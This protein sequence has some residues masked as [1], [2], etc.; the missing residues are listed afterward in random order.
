MFKIKAGR[1]EKSSRGQG[2]KKLKKKKEE[3]R[4]RMEEKNYIMGKI[5][6]D[7]EE[8][9]TNVEYKCWKIRSSRR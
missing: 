6:T 2:R 7:E 5:K 9:R 8:Q 3:L 4:P 1:G